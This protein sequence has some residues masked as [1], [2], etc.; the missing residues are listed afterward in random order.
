MSTGSPKLST[1]VTVN[2]LVPVLLRS[3]TRERPF[4]PGS[5]NASSRSSAT[6]TPPTPRPS[7]PN[8]VCAE[9]GPLQAPLPLAS[10]PRSWWRPRRRVLTYPPGV[11][12]CQ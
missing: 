3:R 10:L 2:S 6:A 5:R 12:V 8:A 4:G 9:Q 11:F 7:L 1:R